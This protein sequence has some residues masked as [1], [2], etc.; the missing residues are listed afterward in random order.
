MNTSRLFRNFV[1]LFS[2]LGLGSFAWGDRFEILTAN[3]SFSVWL[4][5]AN[6]EN[7][8]IQSLTNPSPSRC[9]MYYKD[10]D[11]PETAIFS[12][13][14]FYSSDQLVIPGPCQLRVRSNYSGY[15]TTALIRISSTTTHTTTAKYASV[16]PENAKTNVSVILEQSTDLVNWTAA[17]PGDFSP[18]TSKRFFRVRTANVPVAITGASNAAPIVITSTAHGLSTGDAISVSGVAGNTAANGV[19]TITK[20]DDNSFSLNGATGNAAYTSGG[21]WLPSP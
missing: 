13:S 5:V 3:N 11:T 10:A 12:G 14:V 4:T 2:L 6:G 16:I 21:T 7:A 1:F 8:T 19:F 20:V 15:Q 18:S 9:Y 17:N